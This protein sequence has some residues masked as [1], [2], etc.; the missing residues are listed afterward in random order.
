[1]RKPFRPA[2]VCFVE[3]DVRRP[4]AGVPVRHRHGAKAVTYQASRLD[5]AKEQDDPPPR[6]KAA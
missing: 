5:G 4:T 6:R 3:A 2:V 1:M